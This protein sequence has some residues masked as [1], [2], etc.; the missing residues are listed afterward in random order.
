[1]HSYFTE[2]GQYFLFVDIDWESEESERQF[3]MSSYGIAPIAFYGIDS[4]YVPYKEKGQ[5]LKEVY[6]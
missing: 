5:F 1:M 6:L 3:V 4:G 2:P